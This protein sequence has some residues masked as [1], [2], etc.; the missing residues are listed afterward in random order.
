MQL[1]KL[2]LWRYKFKFLSYI[3]VC[4]CVSFI[5]LLS[6]R[7]CKQFS[8]FLCSRTLRDIFCC[9]FYFL[10][11]RLRWYSTTTH[12][13]FNGIRFHFV[14]RFYFCF[15]GWPNYFR[16]LFYFFDCARHKVILVGSVVQT[17]GIIRAGPVSSTLKLFSN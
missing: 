12:I 8:S 11:P 5:F 4:N 1:Q 10:W 6:F 13:T 9:R 17:D 14:F 3:K 2:Y 7:F 16:T 15:S